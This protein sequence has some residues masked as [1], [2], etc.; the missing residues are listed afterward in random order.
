MTRV[1]WREGWIKPLL[2]ETLPSENCSVCKKEFKDLDF[3][4]SCEFCDIGIIHDSC[5][6]EHVISIHLK[7]LEEKIEK[8]KEKRLHYFQ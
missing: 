8:H 6:K 1:L 7:E 2:T 4:T 3:V 5:A